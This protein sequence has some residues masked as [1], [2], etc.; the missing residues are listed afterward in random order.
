MHL[1]DDQRDPQVVT[2]GRLLSNGSQLYGSCLSERQF[3]DYTIGELTAAR[4]KTSWNHSC[5]VGRCQQRLNL[6]KKRNDTCR[7]ILE[8]II[9]VFILGLP[10]SYEYFL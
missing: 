3:L 6:E 8:K 9:N 2:V 1:P 5:G 7:L 4:K 10:V